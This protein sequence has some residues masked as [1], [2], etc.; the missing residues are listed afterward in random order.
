MALVSCTVQLSHFDFF[1]V[2]VKTTSLHI[3]LLVIPLIISSIVWLFKYFDRP[4]YLDKMPVVI[5]LTFVRLALNQIKFDTCFGRMVFSFRIAKHV[6][7][8]LTDPIS[9]HKRS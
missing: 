8:M 3:K 7:L 2:K 6:M 9:V 5:D 4:S 1:Y